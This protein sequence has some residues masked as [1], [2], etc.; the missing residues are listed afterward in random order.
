VIGYL[1]GQ[2]LSRTGRELL[3][4]VGGVGYLVFASSRFQPK[5]EDEVAIHIRTVVKE[6]EFSLYGFDSVR[7]RDL[8]DALCDVNG[9]GP[10]LAMT[11][12][13]E[14]G[15]EPATAAIA[16]ADERALQA[17]SGVGSK[18]AKLMILS[19][20]G[21]FEAPQL[22]ADSTLIDAL[23]NLGWKEKEAIEALNSVQKPGSSQQETLKSA[24]KYLGGAKTKS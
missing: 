1:K 7:D 15:Y 4:D 6:D 8:F 20:G 21:K 24:L 13:E 19:L 16:S 11:I 9:I 2:I 18:T 14:L 10:K 3:I 5:I 23:I 17:V 22:T 12:I